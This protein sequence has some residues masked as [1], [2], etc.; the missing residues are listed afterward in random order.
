MLDEVV[1]KNYG[2]MM[3]SQGHDGHY[4]YFTSGEHRYTII[5][6]AEL[7]EAELEE[8]LKLSEYMKQHGDENIA[9]FVMSREG[10]FLS[11]TK[12]MLFILLANADR[13][14]NSPFSIAEE[15]AV[16]HNRGRNFA[17]PLSTVNR[18][19]KWKDLWEMR[20]DQLETVWREKLH[21]HPN[22]QFERMFLESFP[23]YM[24]LGENAIQYLVDCE[25]DDE[26]M[27]L[28]A[29]TI[30][31]E[32]FFKETW[33][34][35]KAKN[36]F[37]WVFDHHTR[38]VGEWIRQHYFQYPET[39]Q[40]SM[41]QFM[42]E[43]EYHVPFSPFSWRLLYARLLFPVHYLEVAENYFMTKEQGEKK[44]LQD[45]LDSTLSKAHRYEDFLSRFYELLQVPVTELS[46]PKVDWL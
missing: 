5:P 43:Y 33:S 17:E 35:G 23:Y 19:G 4:R 29:G 13:G 44:A 22:N 46:I 14:N 34:D 39:Y 10:T 42:R 38:D 9:S 32:R 7:D 45:F 18:I 28:D 1:Y 37:D 41:I 36:P 25:I 20:I 2:L 24:S 27:N 8:R 11:E 30:C 3:E 21:A 6:I 15:L 16:F 40:P 31:H 26:P 12:D